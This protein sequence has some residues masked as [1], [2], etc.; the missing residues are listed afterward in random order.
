[1][2]GVAVGERL[3]A[4]RGG[5]E[6]PRPPRRSI[7]QQLRTGGGDED[8]R[9]VDRPLDEVVEEFD[10][11]VV[12]P[13]KVLYHEDERVAGGERLEVALPGIEQLRPLHS[14]LALVGPRQRCQSGENPVGRRTIV[15][16]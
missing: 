2:L 6:L 15:D 1:M 14:G 3:E 12:G 10:E 9:R 13:V 5:V 4:D 11:G 8:D 7:P 16:E